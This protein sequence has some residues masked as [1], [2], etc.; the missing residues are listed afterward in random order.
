[1]VAR[2]ALQP[3]PESGQRAGVGQT[4][5]L[6]TPDQKTG[7][8]GARE[9][10]RRTPETP[11]QVFQKALGVP[12]GS[13]A[14]GACPLPWHLLPVV[15]CFDR[16]LNTTQ[17]LPPPTPATAGTVGDEAPLWLGQAGNP[18]LVSTLQPRRGGL[19]A[20]SREAVGQ[21]SQE[22]LHHE[23]DAGEKS[24]K[25]GPSGVCGPNKGAAKGQV[26]RQGL[27]GD[28]RSDEAPAVKGWT[29]PGLQGT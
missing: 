13:M 24:R 23:A 20:E 25:E 2:P 18:R 5:Q 12:E 14:P 27:Q 21:C 7:G 17:Q 9:Q 10:S 11:A 28:R 6:L 16:P 3:K 1:M 8:S 22:G 4:L 26:L 15:I 29:M 19:R